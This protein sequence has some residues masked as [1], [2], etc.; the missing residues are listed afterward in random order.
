M[1]CCRRIFC[2][3][4]VD[5]GRLQNE[6][7][8]LMNDNPYPSIPMEE[9]DVRVSDGLFLADLGFREAYVSYHAIQGWL[10]VEP[11]YKGRPEAYSLTK[12]M[13]ASGDGFEVYTMEY[14][15]DYKTH[16]ITV[17]IPTET[18]HIATD[19]PYTEI[20]LN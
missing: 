12:D 4:T 1:D 10:L 9:V 11:S 16:T 19:H 17:K 14:G 6:I 3:A 2:C 20:S 18:H 8:P 13:S 15:K 7:S 5:T